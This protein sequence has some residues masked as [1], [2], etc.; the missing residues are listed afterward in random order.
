M[1]EQEINPFEYYNEYTLEDLIKIR[2]M[3]M[4]DIE[5]LKLENKDK[6]RDVEIERLKYLNKVIEDKTN[7]RGM[8]R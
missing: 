8:K 7:E 5:L 4:N 3:T 6:E 2:Q 1:E